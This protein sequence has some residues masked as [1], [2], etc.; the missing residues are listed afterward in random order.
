MKLEHFLTP[1]TDLNVRPETIKVLE[2]NIGGTL[3]DI[4]QSKILCDST[5]KVMEIKTKVNKWDL[6][7]LKSFCIAKETI[8]KVKRQPQNG[9]K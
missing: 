1:Y 7:K 6:I 4:N 3:D 5:P 8:R 2:E 9:R